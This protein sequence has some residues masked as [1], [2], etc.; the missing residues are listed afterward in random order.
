M[1]AIDFGPPRRN[2][3]ETGAWTNVGNVKFEESRRR[4]QRHRLAIAA[5]VDDNVIAASQPHLTR[6]ERAVYTSIF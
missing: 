1:G 3:T 5:V 4:G 6:L 2:I